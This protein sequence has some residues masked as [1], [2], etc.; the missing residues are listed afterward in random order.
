MFVGHG[1][2]SENNIKNIYLPGRALVDLEAL[3]L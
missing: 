2:L 3:Y 1:S